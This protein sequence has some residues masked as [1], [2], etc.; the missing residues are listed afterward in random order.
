VEFVALLSKQ[1]GNHP[2]KTP[3]LA[4]LIENATWW[5]AASMWH[6]LKQARVICER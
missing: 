4:I 3:H 2:F 6:V 1:L 5:K